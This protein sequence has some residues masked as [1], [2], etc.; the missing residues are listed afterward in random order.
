MLSYDPEDNEFP[1]GSAPRT[2]ENSHLQIDRLRVVLPPL[3]AREAHL[4]IL[5]TSYLYGGLSRNTLEEVTEW[6]RIFFSAMRILS[7]YAEIPSRLQTF[8]RILRIVNLESTRKKS[9]TGD[10]RTRPTRDGENAVN[11]LSKGNKEERGG[12]DS[13]S[14][15]NSEKYSRFAEQKPLVGRELNNNIFYEQFVLP[16]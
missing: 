10:P 6:N 7:T 1:K 2:I 3:M 8:G 4:P 5:S 14:V 12:K 16:D 11:A 13:S 9:I 15:E